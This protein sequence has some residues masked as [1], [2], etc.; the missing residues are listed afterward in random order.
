MEPTPVATAK[1]ISPRA[2]PFTAPARL[3]PGDVL[4]FDEIYD[5][6]HERRGADEFLD[7]GHRLIPIGTTG[8]SAAF[9]VG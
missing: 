4:Y 1:L 9:V 8:M 2:V 3:R 7:A 6:F 5:P